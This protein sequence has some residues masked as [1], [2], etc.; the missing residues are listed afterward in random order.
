MSSDCLCMRETY[1]ARELI[2]VGAQIYVGDTSTR[3]HHS[4]V[5]I[6]FL[7]TLNR[8]F[9]YCILFCIYFIRDLVSDSEFEKR[10]GFR[11][12]YILVH[13]L[14]QFIFLR[15]VIIHV[16]KKLADLQQ[17]YPISMSKFQPR[18]R[19][20]NSSSFILIYVF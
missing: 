14:L 5:C 6:F 13:L 20:L 9:C 4:V 3:T 16:T 8:I 7:S 18:G 15:N 2:P 12:T 10:W 19:N 1:R 17:K 11:V